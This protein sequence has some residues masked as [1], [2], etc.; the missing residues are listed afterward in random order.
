MKRLCITTLI[1]GLA[2][3]TT[4]QAEDA[5]QILSATGV[6]GGLVVHLGCGDGRLT[7]ALRADD[8]YLV[9]GLDADEVNV[10]AARE[11]VQSLGMYG[12][13]A[14]DRLTGRTLP[15]AENL[16]N[17]LVAEDLGPVSMD[18]CLRVLAPRGVAYVKGGGA[19]TKTIKPLPE[20]IDEWTHDLHDAGGNAV[21]NDIV[22]GPPGRMQWTAGPLWAR[23][24]GWTPS[25][26]AMVSSGGRLFTICDETLKGVGDAVPSKWFLVARDAFSGVLLWKKPV[27]Q[28][29][30]YEFS[31][32]PNTGG[33]I[34]VGRFTM[35]THAGKRLVAV[36]DTVYVTL[37]AT[38]PVSALDAATGAIRQIYAETENTDEIL[39][40]DGRLILSINPPP[41]ARPPVVD[42]DGTPPPASGKHVCAVDAHSGRLLWKAG[43]FTAVRSGRSQDPFGRLDL[44]AGEGAA[45]EGQVFLLTSEAIE[46]LS[47]ASGKRIWR[48]DRPALPKDAV[49]RLGYSGMYEYLLT[50][51]VYHQ[52]VVL[53]AQP[54]PNTHHTYHTMPGTLYAFAAEDGH[55]MWK[56]AYGGWGHCT[57][58][59]VFVVGDLVWTHVNADTE[60]G[61]VWGKGYRALDSS[62]VDYRIQA[63]DL[64]TGQLQRELSTRDV[65]N[66]GHHHRCYRNKITERYLMSSRRGVEF[67][68][69]ESGENYQNHW[70]RSGC[71]LGNLPCNGLLYVAPHP[72]GCYLNAK[73]TGFNALAAAQ[74]SRT[75]RREA[76]AL[77]T[78]GGRLQRG[79]AYNTD[80]DSSAPGPSAS[81]WPTYRHDPSRS[82]ATES[83]VRTDLEMA[84]QA[85]IGGVLS[86][87]VVADGQVLLAAVDRH[88]VCALNADDGTAVW[89]HTAGARVPTPPTIHAGMAIFGSA[90][91]TVVCLRATDGALAWRFQAAPERRLVTAFGQLESA[92]PVPGVLVQNG[93]CWF[94]AGRSSYLDGGIHVYALEP[95]T[96]KVLREQI[97]YSPNP[98]TGKMTPEPAAATMPGLLNDV[99]G[100]D[101]KSVFLRQQNISADGE[102]TGQ[103][104]YT[105]G[106]FLDSSWFNRT[107]WKIGRAQTT[108]PM[109]LGEGVAYGL[110]PFT[111]RS[112]DVV[113]QPGSGAY[114]IRCLAI[115]S[116]ASDKEARRKEPR[117]GRK[118]PGRGN[119]VWD[120]PVKI[121]AT[122]M[123]RCG[124]TIFV[125]GSPDIV[126]TA[127]PHGAWEGRKGGMLAAFAAADGTPIAE[128]PLP[129]PP[130]WDG[131][132]AADGRLYLALGDGTVVCLQ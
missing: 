22:V 131:M 119:L 33:G 81:N 66:V 5:R 99:P 83:V 84:W 3:L 90:D 111:S 56:H 113:F 73:L 71:L 123:V 77:P 1:V 124:N 49:R 102:N 4:V 40:S 112:R 44:A 30:S 50:V 97:V 78:G 57:P 115:G 7:A 114:R 27:P 23:S 8:G 87:P 31:G 129:A 101:G 130:V 65:F 12:D 75:D 13:V 74:V 93:A 132:A 14:I 19:W 103:H 127:D 88:T 117:P 17:L 37:G 125:A 94:A 116:P 48:I 128:I 72:C 32:T 79:P 15:Y 82:G 126:D 63:L 38:A 120:Q 89:S 108:G 109:V 46:S 64:K 28:W 39:F 24:H 69:L 60:F 76:T 92:W 10:A 43:P 25:V 121:R 16:V 70:V 118:Q 61:S 68:D 20:E 105:T 122:A 26:T 80:A 62:I 6:Q 42:K 55:A 41:H 95:R 106:G 36:G 18:E 2:L 86:A 107:F 53:L 35:P 11:H 54:E 59:D 51:L 96:G 34:S 58:P 104:L 100:S 21:A 67:V 85:D 47:A 98:E 91:G 29:G 110:E 45:G 52:G 9:H